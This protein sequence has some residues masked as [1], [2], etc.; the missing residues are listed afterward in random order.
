[1]KRITL[2]SCWTIGLFL[3]MSVHAAAAA[4]VQLSVAASMTDA[5]KALTEDFKKNHPDIEIRSN[6]AS[7]GALAKQ[8][9]QGAPADIYISANQKWMSYLAEKKLIDTDSMRIFAYNTLVFAGNPK[10]APISIADVVTLKLIAIGTP[11]SVPA[12]QYAKQALTA[13]GL[14]DTLEQGNLLMLTKDVRQALIYADRGEVDG[15]FVYKTDALLAK[16]ATILFSIP[17]KLYDRVAYPIALT[18]IGAVNEAARALFDYL[19][20]PEADAIIAGFG[21]EPAH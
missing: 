16:N 3:F 13:S 12:G 8:I 9:E 5:T 2:A 21:F 6:F 4:S 7:S 20:T 1:M 10:L 18:P 15:A 19:K 11:E 17:D 14:W